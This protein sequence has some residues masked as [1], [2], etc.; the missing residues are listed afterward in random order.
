MLEDIQTMEERALFLKLSIPNLFGECDP[1]DRPIIDNIP[2][3]ESPTVA[4]Q[5]S[6]RISLRMYRTMETQMAQADADS[7]ESLLEKDA[8]ASVTA[9]TETEKTPTKAAV[10]PGRTSILWIPPGKT[11]NGFSNVSGTIPKL[12][13]QTSSGSS[14]SS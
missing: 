4:V 11:I 5:E 2:S 7:S 10:K 14:P 9:T 3:Q 1:K 13:L 8:S 6:R 12:V